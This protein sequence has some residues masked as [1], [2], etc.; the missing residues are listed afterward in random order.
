MAAFALA[1]P[2]TALQHLDAALALAPRSLPVLA[3]RAAALL[4]L[5][6]NGALASEAHALALCEAKAVVL[7][8]GRAHFAHKSAVEPWALAALELGWPPWAWLVAAAELSARD[9]DLSAAEEAL[10]EGLRS[11]A[12][13]SPEAQSNLWLAIGRVLC[14]AYAADH[15]AS[16]GCASAS[17]LTVRGQQQASLAVAAPAAEPTVSSAAW[18][19]SSS[20]HLDS[21][22]A[23]ADRVEPSAVLQVLPTLPAAPVSRFA[24]DKLADAVDAFANAT[25]CAPLSPAAHF[26]AGVASHELALQRGGGAAPDDFMSRAE[27]FLAR[28]LELAPDRADIRVAYARALIERAGRPSNPPPSSSAASELSALA[29]AAALLRAVVSVRPTDSTARLLLGVALCRLGKLSEARSCLAGCEA[30]LSAVGNGDSVSQD[31][32]RSSPLGGALTASP[33]EEDACTARVHMLTSPLHFGLTGHAVCSLAVQ[34]LPLAC[35]FESMCALANAH[36]AAGELAAAE[37]LHRRLLRALPPVLQASLAAHGY[38]P[39]Y[40]LLE[41]TYLDAYS[42][43]V[44]TLAG[45]A[46]REPVQ[47]LCS[48]AG[49][50]GDGEESD[51]SEEEAQPAADEP[52]RSPAQLA[53]A[54]QGCMQLFTL[55]QGRL[56]HSGLAHRMAGLA[57]RLAPQDPRAHFMRGE[58]ILDMPIA[59]QSLTDAIGSLEMAVSLA[60]R[61]C[62][63]RILDDA[64]GRLALRALLQPDPKSTADPLAE[65]A[66]AAAP[67]AAL[68]AAPAAAPG[69]A[70]LAEPPSHIG[71]PQLAACVS[72]PP[73][74]FWMAL[75]RAHTEAGSA[76]SVVEGL[77]AQAIS[78]APSEVEAYLELGRLLECRGAH[79]EALRVYRCYSEGATWRGDRSARAEGAGSVSLGVPLDFNCALLENAIASLLVS[80]RRYANEADADRLVVALGRLGVVL[81]V[82]AIEKFVVALDLADQVD[83][84]KRAYMLCLPVGT[85]TAAFFRHKGWTAE[86]GPIVV[87][88]HS[89]L[90]GERDC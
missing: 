21:G 27:E 74:E 23:E 63:Q 6:E 86:H 89:S 67:P 57:V 45:A 36:A 72:S 44:T 17:A 11:P 3:G 5:A 64:S 42:G 77:Y 51:A 59:G 82:L 15:A 25:A 4:A 81:G 65:L 58:A 73:Q 39:C 14:T 79:D 24:V 61:G 90:L 31:L 69:A 2:T 71:E 88:A 76:T 18:P 10:K 22:P 54:L 70:S 66:P 26:A 62:A 53:L 68:A 34:Q 20:S 78:L 16:A 50:R 52:P 28:A 47:P 1:R 32:S 85:D 29:Q 30:A 8:Q 56:Q 83:L 75:A 38:T 40:L 46:A 48:Q 9:G 41:A 49:V 13:E 33:A 80:Q 84:I 37:A 7:A 43:L 19:P 35:V 55:V 12:C 87:G 60:T